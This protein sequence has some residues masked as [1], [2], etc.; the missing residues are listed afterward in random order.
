MSWR[1]WG[2]IVAVGVGASYELLKYTVSTTAAYVLVGL[3]I[4]AWIA[5]AVFYRWRV[6]RLRERF[7]ELSPEDQRR[8]LKEIDP[9][10]GADLQKGKEN[11]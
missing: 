4:A 10:V 3:L 11:D 8:V 7:S 9:D 2:I 6:A 5:V 1:A